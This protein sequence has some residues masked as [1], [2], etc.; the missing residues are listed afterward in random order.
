MQFVVIAYDY[1]DKN[2]LQRRLAVREEH[3]KFA[4]ESFKSGKWHF[5]SALLDNDGNMNGSIIACEYESET[6]LRELWL[7]KEIYVKGN[8]W[9]KVIIRKGKFA[10]HNYQN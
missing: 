1:K 2:A 9:E 3:L 10:K 6:D 5:A 4:E 8:V 7:D